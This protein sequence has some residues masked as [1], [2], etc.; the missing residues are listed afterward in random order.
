MEY[1]INDE[2]PLLLLSKKS[3]YYNKRK[4]INIPLSS[5]ELSYEPCATVLMTG[6]I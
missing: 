2:N 1:F 4:L 3:N 6:N 5:H